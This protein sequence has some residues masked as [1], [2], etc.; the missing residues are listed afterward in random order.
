MLKS[1][2]SDNYESNDNVNSIWSSDQITSRLSTK[3]VDWT[4]IPDRN[5]TKHKDFIEGRLKAKDDCGPLE[6]TRKK[7]MLSNEVVSLKT[8]H[9]TSPRPQSSSTSLQPDY[10]TRHHL[11]M[12]PEHINGNVGPRQSS[13]HLNNNNLDFSNKS[14]NFWD[15]Y[16]QH[17]FH[18]YHHHH[19]HHHQQDQQQVRLNSST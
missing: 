19:H 3:H 14:K 12:P 7:S 1:E 6:K 9:S 4:D 10:P 15:D 8:D 13:S 17:D 5:L 18:R 16:R 11:Y 2:T